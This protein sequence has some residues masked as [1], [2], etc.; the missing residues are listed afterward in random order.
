MQ[1]G[2]PNQAGGDMRFKPVE[3]NCLNPPFES[4]VCP[5]T[6][7]MTEHLNG[8]GDTELYWTD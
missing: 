6:D 1:T 4:V 8:H 7:S 2:I 5:V 3:R